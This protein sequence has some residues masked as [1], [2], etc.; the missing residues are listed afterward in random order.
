MLTVPVL[1]V[2][3]ES[4]GTCSFLAAWDVMPASLIADY[5]HATRPSRT[6]SSETRLVI[7]SGTE[8]HSMKVLSR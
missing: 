1:A 5:P 7:V 8:R 6:L 2:N 3:A 4:T